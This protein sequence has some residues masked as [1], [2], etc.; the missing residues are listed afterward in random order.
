M[1]GRPPPT[2]SPNA[3][4]LSTVRGSVPLCREQQAVLIQGWYVDGNERARDALVRSV[5][6]CVVATAQKYRRYGLPLEE[7]VSEGNFGVVRA[8]A[9]FDPGR[10]TSF[11]TYA[12][13][14]IRACILQ[15]VLRSWSIVGSGIPR[16]RLFFKLRRERA[17]VACVIGDDTQL[18]TVLAER[19]NLSPE[20]LRAL[21]QRVECRDFSLEAET[22]G[23][24]RSLRNALPSS[25]PNQEQRTLASEFKLRAAHAVQQALSVLNPRERY[26]IESRLLAD[27]ETE[28]SLA[29]L[30]RKLNISRERARQLEGRAKLKLK[31]Q[32]A[33]Q[34]G[35]SEWL[36]FEHAA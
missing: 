17:R 22:G 32:I 11:I 25:E 34:L 18:E 36:S 7:L 15:H 28:F 5:L 14:W 12:G 8:L 16:S 13:Y 35:S 31:R 19:L 20:R 33:G 1:N 4:F 9:K 2:K 29:E 24:G 23:E 27:H 10:G 3:H 30:A 26:I 6:R 21:L